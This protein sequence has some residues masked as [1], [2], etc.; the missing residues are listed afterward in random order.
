M[1]EMTQVFFVCGV[2]EKIEMTQMF[3]VCGV[4]EKMHIC[5]YIYIR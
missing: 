2:K 1:I 4:K 3:F 5:I